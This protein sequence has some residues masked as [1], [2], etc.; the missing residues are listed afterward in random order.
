MTTS[1]Q[2]SEL[3][4]WLVRHICHPENHKLLGKFPS[5]WVG[6]Y[7]YSRGAAGF[8]TPSIP[9]RSGM[10]YT[11]GKGWTDKRPDPPAIR[12]AESHEPLFH[13]ETNDYRLWSETRRELNGA[14]GRL[15]EARCRWCNARISLRTFETVGRKGHKEVC[16][17]THNLRAVFDILR[18][19]GQCVVCNRHTPEETW[20]LP[21]CCARCKVL[22]MQSARHTDPMLRAI[23][24]AKLAGTLKSFG[25][26]IATLTYPAV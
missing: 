14:G 7:S 4:R 26:D 6:S 10:F 23:E 12:Q 3:P 13:L 11:P 16:D 9:N 24:K 15:I 5:T 19:R 1:T 18:E 22:W 21:I 20:G 2:L 17:F 8:H 25:D